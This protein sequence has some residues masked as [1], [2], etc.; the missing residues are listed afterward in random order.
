MI[1]CPNGCGEQLR[2][3]MLRQHRLKECDEQALVCPRAKDA[4]KCQFPRY[5]KVGHD[6][7]PNSNCEYANER[8]LSSCREFMMSNANSG[9]EQFLE[10]EEIQDFNSS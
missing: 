8:F 9:G 6:T 10:V 2:L 3:N 1:G 7:H 5:E 4:T